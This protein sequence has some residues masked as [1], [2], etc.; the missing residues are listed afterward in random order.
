MHIQY[1]S[2]PDVARARRSV[3]AQL[4]TKM[5]RF[6]FLAALLAVIGVAVLAL[7]PSTPGEGWFSVYIG[8]ACLACA[9]YY[10]AWP[11]LVIRRLA[12][13]QMKLR[14]Q[15]AIVTIT[16]DEI[17]WSTTT[18]RVVWSWAAFTSVHTVP[19]FWMLRVNG[20]NTVVIDH[21]DLSPDQLSDMRSFM[22]TRGLVPAMYRVS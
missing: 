2:T 13:R 1:S 14:N 12:D 4:R 3:R 11:T 18:H 21:D 10:L 22:A 17:T 5:R 20:I 8:V 7:R 9:V 16:D 15:P 6:P 19:G